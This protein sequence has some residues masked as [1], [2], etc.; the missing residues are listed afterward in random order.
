MK[1]IHV[2]KIL[3]IS[4]LS[5]YYKNIVI[6]VFVNEEMNYMEKYEMSFLMSILRIFI[7]EYMNIYEISNDIIVMELLEKEG[8]L[9]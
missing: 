3:L 1:F 5:L 8:V 7:N 6:D 9:L 4:F 2:I